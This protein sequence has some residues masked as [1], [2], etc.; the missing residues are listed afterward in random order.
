KHAKRELVRGGIFPKMSRKDSQGRVL[1]EGGVGLRKNEAYFSVRNSFHRNPI[2]ASSSRAFECR[3]LS[4]FNS[5]YHIIGSYSDSVVKEN[6]I[7]KNKAV[8]KSVL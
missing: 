3:V 8:F 2:P 7:L 6:L 4:S 1:K 5:K